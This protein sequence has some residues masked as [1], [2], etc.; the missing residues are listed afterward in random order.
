MKQTAFTS[1]AHIKPEKGLNLPLKSKE[2]TSYQ[3]ND[4]LFDF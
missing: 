3:V 4:C 2:L 1:I